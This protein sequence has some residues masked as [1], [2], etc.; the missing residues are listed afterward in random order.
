MWVPTVKSSCD[1]AWKNVSYIEVDYIVNIK[2]V[3]QKKK[4][5][6]K[7]TVPYIEVQLT[8]EYRWKKTVLDE[9]VPYIRSG[10]YRQ[11]SGIFKVTCLMHAFM[12]HE[13]GKKIVFEKYS[14][15][16]VCPP[17][18][19]NGRRRRTVFLWFWSKY[20]TCMCDTSFNMYLKLQNLIMRL[21][22]WYLKILRIFLQY[23][24]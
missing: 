3:Q 15:L 7:C 4:C 16:T 14:F 9:N 17:K 12:G 11:K 21:I 19:Q 5:C 1:I 6:I 23:K 8:N 20:Q 22:L 24:C 13:K 18:N 10:L 2:F